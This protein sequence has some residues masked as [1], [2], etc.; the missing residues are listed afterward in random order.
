MVGGFQS[1]MEKEFLDLLLRGA[2]GAVVCPARGLCVMRLPRAWRAPLN[3]GR[4]LVLSFFD[5][6]VRRPTAAIA[7]R[8]N[9]GNYIGKCPNGS[10]R[11]QAVDYGRGS[12]YRTVK[13]APAPASG[14]WI[15]S[16]SV[17]IASRITRQ[18]SRM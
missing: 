10:L 16:S 17:R 7:A 6:A 4:L 18:Q 12:R 1:P 13:L 2:A 5:E 14:L 3:D 8:R 9:A 15:T 11:P